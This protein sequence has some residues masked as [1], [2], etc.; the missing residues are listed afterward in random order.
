[1]DTYRGNINLWNIE[2]CWAIDAAAQIC[3]FS[4]SGFTAEA[5]QD[6]FQEQ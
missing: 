4:R 3:G 1:M 5:A 6:E 2:K